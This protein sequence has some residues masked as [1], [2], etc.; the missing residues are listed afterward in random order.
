MKKMMKLCG[1]SVVSTILLAHDSA[2]ISLASLRA[3]A[4]SAVSSAKKI[5]SSVLDGSLAKKASSTLSKAGSIVGEVAKIVPGGQQV[6]SAVQQK[7]QQADAVV[8]KAAQTVDVAK[9]AAQSVTSAA[10]NLRKGNIQQAIA[11]GGK[12]IQ[13]AGTVVSS[14]PGTSAA[15]NILRK[16]ESTAVQV[17]HVAG[18]VGS[19]VAVLSGTQT[20]AAQEEAASDP[21][22]KLLQTQEQMNAAEQSQSEAQVVQ[23]SVEEPVSPETI[24]KVDPI[25]ERPGQFINASNLGLN[26]SDI[27]YFCLKLVKLSEQGYDKLSVDLSD[28]QI[29]SSGVRRIFEISKDNPKLLAMLN[30]SGNNLG[31]DGAITIAEF[32]RFAPVMTRLHLSKTSI[33][34]EGMGIILKAVA[35][36]GNTTLAHID[37]SGNQVSP[38]HIP[39]LAEEGKFLETEALRDGMTISGIQIPQGTEIPRFLKIRQA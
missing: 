1:C 11:D 5:G 27:R 30:M 2:S 39:L 20:A 36:S 14:V 4:S 12:G 21:M 7:I 38:E 37:F 18:A 10:D 29:T 6:A 17:Q 19:G 8:N 16:A 28:N 13:A 35:D 25:F 22:Q 32:I 34:G 9:G 31:Q 23:E 3:K 33:T 24:A 26:D 15:Q